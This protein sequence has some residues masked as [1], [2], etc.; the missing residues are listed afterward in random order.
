MG[1]MFWQKRLLLQWKMA[2]TTLYDTFEVSETELQVVEENTEEA[3]EA[4]IEEETE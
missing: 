2:D 4:I 1:T 3:T